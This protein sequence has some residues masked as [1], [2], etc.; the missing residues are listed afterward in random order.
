MDHKTLYNK[1]ESLIKYSIYP[2]EEVDLRKLKN[3]NF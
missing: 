2:N 3:F 1:G